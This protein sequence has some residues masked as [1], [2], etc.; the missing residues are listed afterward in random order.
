MTGNVSGTHLR[1]R[2]VCLYLKKFLC[3]RRAET[4]WAPPGNTKGGSIA[5]P[6]TSYLTG[7]ESAYDN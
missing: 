6:L 7:L 2:L 4:T 1:N 5:V 3:L